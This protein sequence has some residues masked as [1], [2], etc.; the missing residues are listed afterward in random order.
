MRAH[1]ECASVASILVFE[2][3]ASELP[4]AQKFIIKQI[5]EIKMSL[6]QN[7]GD[8][9]HILEVIQVV[10]GELAVGRRLTGKNAKDTSQMAPCPRCKLWI[11]ERDMSRHVDERCC[12]V[13]LRRLEAKLLQMQHVE[14]SDDE[15]VCANANIISCTEAVTMSGMLKGSCTK[16]ISD[17][18]QKEV[19]QKLQCSSECNVC[20]KA[21]CVNHCAI[22]DPMICSLGQEW[23]CKASMNVNRRAGYASE[24]MRRAPWVLLNA[25]VPPSRFIPVIPPI[26][27]PGGTWM[28]LVSTG[29]NRDDP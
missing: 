5:V 21:I 22:E 24:R 12:A 20:N 2:E 18:L 11:S 14:G 10:E 19:L 29:M 23:M 13:T 27:Q 15:V 6:L 1:Q 7:S 26:H 28:N 8:Y 25:T 16:A 9:E 4:E 17:E 3:S